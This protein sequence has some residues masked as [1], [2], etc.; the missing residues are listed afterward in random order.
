MPYIPSTYLWYL[1]FYVQ[2]LED[3]CP[4]PVFWNNISRRYSE[5]F[6]EVHRNQHPVTWNSK[7]HNECCWFNFLL[8]LISLLFYSCI[9]GSCLKYA[10]YMQILDSGSTFEGTHPKVS[11]FEQF[12][13][14][15]PKETKTPS[16]VTQPINDG[17]IMANL[18]CYDTNFMHW[19]YTTADDDWISFQ[20]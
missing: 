13:F 15:L 6:S 7:L 18:V 3:K 20:F 5:L 16:K 12:H 10:I 14:I 19:C 17:A 9:L 1:Q 4:S 11:I 2:L 8:S